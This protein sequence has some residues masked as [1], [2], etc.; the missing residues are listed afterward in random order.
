MTRDPD[1]SDGGITLPNATG[2]KRISWSSLPAEAAAAIE[3]LLGSTVVAAADQPGG[4]SEG[5]A[6][7]VRLADGRLVFVK[8]ACT[9]TAPAAAGFHRREIAVAAQL[10]AHAA[11]SRLLASHDDGVWVALAFENIPGRLPA[12]PWQRDDLDRVL[13]AVTDLTRAFTPSPVDSAVLGGPRLGGWLQLAADGT[14]DRL[15]P[16]S[17]WAV[18]H[19]DDLARLEEKSSLVLSGDSLQHGDLYPFNIMLTD[20]RVFV[21]DWPHAWLGAAHCD[22]VTLLS[23]SSLSGVDPQPL[24]DAHPLTRGLASEQIDV[25]L[26]MHAGFLLRIASSVGPDADRK[27]VAMMVALARGSLN[28]LRARL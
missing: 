20:D 28:W 5:L 19:L 11:V 15:R 6:A 10:P 18:D 1:Q 13:D 21:I 2:G 14:V 25:V 26:A 8:A 12:Q 17:S 16:L 7:K 4:F 24:A 22:V 23:S 9:T 3:G 27:L